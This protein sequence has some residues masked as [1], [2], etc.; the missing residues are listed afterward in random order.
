MRVVFFLLFSLLLLSGVVSPLRDIP[1]SS[2]SS[3]LHEH[4]HMNSSGVHFTLHHPRGPCSPA[5]LQELS[6]SD[7]LQHD[8]LRV[9]GLTS[10]LTTTKHRHR[11]RASSLATN[12]PSLVSVPLT[13][14][15]SLGVGN[16]ITKIGLGTPASYFSMVVDTGSSLTWLQCSPC[17]ISCHDQSGPLFDPSASSTY[18]SVPCSSAECSGL[19]SATLNPSACSSSHVCIYEASYGDS[20]FSVG[21]LSKDTLTIGSSPALSG[22]TYGCGQ[23]NEGLFGHSAGLIG[24]AKDKLSLLSQ[25]APK[26]G[27][28]FSYCL[29]TMSSTGSLSIGSYDPSHFV[30]TPLVKS[31]LDNS[32]YFV[33]LS[34]IKVGGKVLSVPA[35]TYSDTPTII[36]SGT[37]ITRLP[38]DVYTELSSAVSN[39]LSKYP[40]APAY[41]LLD[42]CFK[43]SAAGLAAPEVVV[44][45]EGGA[46]WNLATRNVFIDVDDGTTCLAFAS[47]GRVAIIGNRLQ[48]T[49]KVVYD[50]ANSKLGFAAGGCG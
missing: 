30:F 49:F 22:F 17:R 19:Q 36:D 13:P 18:H 25:L 32:L 45:F 44:V 46:E 11:H 27:N 23:D 4:Q 48:Q 41:S 15:S 12:H 14:G 8:V 24:L 26:L 39:A 21:Y 43:G 16:Y 40:S 50:V 10:R 29:P 6:F 7:V 1:H 5:S 37:V 31:S 2:C 42:T 38:P 47:A 9:S 34:G 28:A 20:S 35:S 3:K 33:K